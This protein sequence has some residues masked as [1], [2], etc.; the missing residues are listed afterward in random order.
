[1]A[2]ET[3]FITPPRDAWDA[4]TGLACFG[5]TAAEAPGQHCAA[6]VIDQDSIEITLPGR[7]LDDAE[8]E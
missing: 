8:T 2:F 5:R 7:A 6:D 3:L 1:M 4:R